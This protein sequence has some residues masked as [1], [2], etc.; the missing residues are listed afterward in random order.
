MRKGGIRFEQSAIGG[1][2]RKPFSILLKMSCQFYS[3]LSLITS[4]ERFFRKV[5][6]EVLV[7]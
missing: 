5:L 2:S 7:K 4:L 6:Y 1:E 3:R